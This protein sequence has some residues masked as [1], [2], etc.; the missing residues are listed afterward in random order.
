MACS[1]YEQER[2][3]CDACGCISPCRPV[4]GLHVLTSCGVDVL[5]GNTDPCLRCLMAS[6]APYELLPVTVT[7]QLLPVARL[8]KGRTVHVPW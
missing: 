2:I 8:S 6:L 1:K 7:G 3:T 5:L 4:A